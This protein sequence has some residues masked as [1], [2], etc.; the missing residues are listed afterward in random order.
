MT[1]AITA[2]AISGYSAYN[3]NKNA[4]K[5]MDQQG[6]ALAYQNEI[7]QQELDMAKEQYEYYK[8]TYRPLE[9]EIVA[10][11]GLSDAEQQEMVTT[12]GLTTQSAFDSAEA[13]RNR[14]LQRMG[15]NPNSGAYAENTRK[16]AISKAVAKANSQNTARSQAEE[17]DYNQKVAAVGLGKGLSSSAAGLMS[18][19]SSNYANQ[20]SAYGL[21]AQM[22][23]QQASGSVQMGMGI[24]GV[25]MGAYDDKGNFN[26]SQFGKGLLGIGGF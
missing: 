5:S 15:V 25:A 4:N 14:N 19:A 26:Q 12:A 22:Y 18:S 3:S 24:A 1:A 17:I 6:Q 8:T 2:V 11:A 9:E 21:N 23:G 10:N 13:S 16:S 7:A 20:A